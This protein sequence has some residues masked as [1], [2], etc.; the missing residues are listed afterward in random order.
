MKDKA[1]FSRGRNKN[2]LNQAYKSYADYAFPNDETCHPR[3]ENAGDSVL[4][5]PTNDESQLPNWKCALRKCT[6][7]T[8]IA[9]PGVE[10]DSSNR[11]PMI[12]FNTYRAQF[13]CS[14]NGIPIREKITTYLDAKG[15]SKII[16]S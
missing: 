7:C 10:M 3:C 8:Y 4:C 9:L 2:E 1:E 12:K 5:S 13:T 6:A 14:H 11:A 16:V 15:T